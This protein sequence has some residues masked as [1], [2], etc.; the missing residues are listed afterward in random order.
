MQYCSETHQVL[1]QI[2]RI[3]S[4]ELGVTVE[5]VFSTENPDEFVMTEIRFQNQAE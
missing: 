1:P 4:S 5:V 3:K 2:L